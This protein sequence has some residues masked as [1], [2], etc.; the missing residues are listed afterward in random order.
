MRRGGGK[1]GWIKIF[2]VLPPFLRVRAKKSCVCVC[3]CG[4]SRFFFRNACWTKAGSFGPPR[5]TVF[6]RVVCVCVS[7][8]F[9]ESVQTKGAIGVE[10]QRQ[11]AGLWGRGGSSFLFFSSL[12]FFF[13]ALLVL[14]PL[15]FGLLRGFFFSLLLL[16]SFFSCSNVSP[17][18]LSLS[19]VFAGYHT[20]HP[21]RQRARRVRIRNAGWFVFFLATFISAFFFIFG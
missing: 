1:V 20:H 8:C 5:K 11:R 9:F 10:E 7:V 6:L 18:S 14:T 21:T 2:W 17:L 16:S 19:L 15:L 4:D 3:V 13:W 12:V